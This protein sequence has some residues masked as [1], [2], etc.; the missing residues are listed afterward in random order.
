MFQAQPG[1]GSNLDQGLTQGDS[2]Y[3]KLGPYPGRIQDNSGYLDRRAQGGNPASRLDNVP[4]WNYLLPGACPGTDTPAEMV[5]CLSSSSGV[6]FSDSILDTGRFGF[7]PLLYESNF[8]N[9]ST[10]YHIAGF[11]PVFLDTTYYGCN[12]STCDI[13]H[14]PGVADSGACPA[15]P[16]SITC[17]T[18]GTGNKSLQAVTAYILRSDLLPAAAQTPFP[19]AANQ[20]TYSLIK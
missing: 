14:T 5:A 6:I 18:P 1:V 9:P 11:L 7:T 2:A 13:V 17:G 10:T 8:G 12:A 19:G 20:R 4:L 3:S 16:G 15:Q